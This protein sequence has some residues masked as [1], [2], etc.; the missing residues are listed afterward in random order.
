MSDATD[1]LLT[2][3][4]PV[5]N[6]EA[7]LADMLA[8]LKAQ[9]VRGFELIVVDNASTDA[10]RA[11]AED[12]ARSNPDIPSRVLSETRRGAAS[13]RQCGLEAVTTPWTLFFDSDDYMRP[14]HIETVLAAIVKERDADIIGWDLQ[15]EGPGGGRR[16]FAAG[17]YRWDNI[18]R[19]GFATLRYCARTALFREA[20][21][22][23]P[24]IGLWDDIELG[25]RLLACGPK[26]VKIEKRDPD[27]RVRFT[28]ESISGTSYTSQIARMEPALQAMAAT[29]GPRRAFLTDIKRAH[30]YGC[31]ARERAASAAS[32]MAELL[33]HTPK[34]SRRFALRFLYETTRAGIRGTHLLLRLFYDT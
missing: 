13:A 9:T 31:A 10:S 22:W 23:N 6:R 7:L 14:R 29:L 26:I 3:V 17:S 16:R 21:G 4:V 30:T 8:S 20:G 25:M 12:W 32:A 34:R 24:G 1:A 27:V 5:F 28:P 11:V 15:A 2:V 33:K 18:M 19:G